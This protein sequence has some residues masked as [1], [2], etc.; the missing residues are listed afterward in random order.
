[1]NMTHER[2]R[3]APVALAAQAALLALA[4]MPAWAEDAAVTDLT[5]PTSTIELGLGTVNKASAKFGE[6]NGLDRKGHFFLGGFDLAGPV[7]NDSA[8]RFRLR[9]SN[10]GL[11]NRNISG[12]WGEQGKFRIDFGY[13]ELERRYSDSYQTIYQGGGGT[14]LT[15]PSS[16]PAQGTRLSST[17]TANGLLSNWNN[18]QSPYGTTAAAAAGGATLGNPMAGS[19]AASILA[20]LHPLA[21]GTQRTRTDLGG[22]FTLGRWDFKLGVREDTRDGTKLTGVAFGGQRGA[23]LPEPI[24][25]WTQ[26]FET[27]AAYVGQ[28]AQATLTYTSSHFVNY[29]SLWTAQNPF[30]NNALLDNQARLSSAPSNDMQQWALAGGY[31]LTPT[32]RFS[33]SGSEAILTQN[34][35]FIP[36]PTAAVGWVV[37]E[38]SAD[39]R[40]VNTQFMGRLTA[41]PLTGVN[42]SASYKYDNREN[43]TP[44]ATFRTA[45]AD[46][47]GGT[48]LFT[49][50]PNLR[51]TQ[52]AQFD[53]DY[54][55]A[56]G[57]TIKGGY[58]WQQIHRE[59][60]TYSETP[61]RAE[62]TV[63]NA[64]R[65]EYRDSSSEVLSGRVSYQRSLRKPNEYEEGD[66]APITQ[67]APAPAADPE[68]PGFRQF[69]LAQRQ[70]DKLRSSLSLQATDEL[71]L[72]AGVDY[73]RDRYT[74]S[75]YGTKEVKLSSANLD[76]TYA[77]NETWS[78]NT[79]YSF[80]SNRSQ[81]DSLAIT[82]FN[83]ATSVTTT[84]AGF[85][86]LAPHVSGGACAAWASN[87]GQRGTT[88]YGGIPADYYTDPC[89][90]WSEVQSD[91]VQTVGVGGKAR[92]LMGGR[93]ELS[94]DLTYSR[95]VT[96]MTVTGGAYYSNGLPGLALNNVWIPASSLP[97][98]TSS[99]TEIRL[100]GRYNL[101][102]TQAVR[103]N[104]LNRR[105]TSSDW[106]YDLYASNPLAMQAYIGS[107][108]TSPNYNVTAV[109][110]TYILSFK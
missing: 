110:L 19:P 47:T 84:A 36:M 23:L 17:T 35:L 10:L 66:P 56:R 109:G 91:R 12:E 82:R 53:A 18:I 64:F 24:Q 13:D 67:P 22:T 94:A 78:F 98:V 85:T 16:Y 49:N 48:S 2:F 39:A 99:A 34:A 4:S 79:F 8:F 77:P 40:V 65:L 46:G 61:F 102:K 44:S 80:E 28:D 72:Q 89:R 11:H 106:Q 25:T 100:S 45:G 1:M 87:I 76:A 93:V 101:D 70:R 68:L 107:A 37:P 6:Y 14:S 83:S 20:A 52:T 62:T 55:F 38:A 95:A 42:L 105:L 57:R 73:T 50:E 88:F 29:N 41:R 74:D 63:E 32:T 31:N 15:L 9:G 96:P 54:S 43:K 27:S 7:S 60:Q 75:A 51:K 97:D 26:Q 59:G 30:A 81:V 108:I 69:W 103:V 58:E 104:V 86:Y 90:M 3:T 92:G 33:Y 5:Q 71:T 21:I